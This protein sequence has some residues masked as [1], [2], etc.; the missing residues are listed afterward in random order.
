MEISGSHVAGTIAA[1]DNDE[2][3]V[4]VYPNAPKMLIVKVFGEKMTDKCNWSYTSALIGAVQ[5]CADAGAKII[6]MS[7]GLV[8]SDDYVQDFFQGLN[9]DEGILSIAAA[10]NGGNRALH[11]PA[12]YP[13]VMSVAAMGNNNTHAWF[14]QANHQVDIAAPG[15]DIKSTIKGGVGSYSGTSMAAPHVTGVA[16]LLWNNFANCT[17]DEIRN[18]LEMSA[19]DIGV[20]GRDDE[21]GHGVVNYHAAVRYLE[22]V[23]PCGTTLP[24]VPSTAP[25]PCN[26]N[27]FQ[28]VL[29]TGMYS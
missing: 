22:D 9:N 4:G 25:T 28:L 23:L 26:G 21:F 5:K 13:A 2:H 29:S 7:L 11:F 16:F 8:S 14:S 17:N 20:P 24:P 10:G 12:S 19:I 3:V 27:E 18:A 6:N 15:V 1:K